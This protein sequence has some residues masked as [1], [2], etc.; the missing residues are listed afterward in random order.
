[1]SALLTAT[2]ADAAR[3][4][5]R[6]P[7]VMLLVSN[8]GVGG[9]ER[10][11]IQLAHLLA[12][13]FDVVLGYLKDEAAMAPQIRRDALRAV[14]CLGVAR[15]LD[16]GAV[17]RLAGVFAEHRVDL[18]L[19]ANTFPLMYA[20]LARWRHG[21]AVQVVEI[22]HTTL[23]ASASARLKLLLYRPLFWLSR[24]LVFVCEAQ[25][26]HC[27][28]RA[29]WAPRVSVIH[30]GVDTA[31]FWRP[32]PP[33][34]QARARY[35]LQ[36]EDRVVGLCAVFRPEKAHR[37]LLEAV[38]ALKARG[39]VWKVLLIG[40]G[41]MRPRIEADITRLGLRDEVRIT[42]YLDDVREAVAACDLMAL[43][44]TSIETFSVAA[45]EAMA[46]GRPMLMSDIG[47][48]AEQIEQ[49][50]SGELFRA[51]D[52][53]ALTERLAALADRERC[54]A[55]GRAARQRV[56]RLFSQEAMRDRYV[57]LVSELLAPEAVRQRS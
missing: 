2:R 21:S 25:R 42:G 8:L 14:V 1:L 11:T 53:E 17:R 44:S 27:L 28:K 56:E 36:A 24:Q 45:L 34:P 20:Q 4:P 3:A 33:S 26:R 19:C 13:R 57:A 37:D 12:E 54:A 18:V 35:G 41:P 16:K 52:V 49:G 43:V 47:G 6:R 9:A 40:D 32:G 7:V 15:R 46:L 48:A 23:V 5:S 10:H 29:L 51:G 50:I 39:V 38:A 55:M 22:Y 31:H 30:N